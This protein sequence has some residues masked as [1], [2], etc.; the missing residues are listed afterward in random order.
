MSR[1][2]RTPC[3]SQGTSADMMILIS[4]DDLVIGRQKIGPLADGRSIKTE[5]T[6]CA[7]KKCENPTFTVSL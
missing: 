7:G 2:N 1:G 5:S 3:D 6:G 4:Q